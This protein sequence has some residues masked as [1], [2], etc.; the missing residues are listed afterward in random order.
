MIM[1]LSFQGL[2][3]WQKNVFWHVG[4][5]HDVCVQSSMNIRRRVSIINCRRNATVDLNNLLPC[6]SYFWSNFALSL[7][8]DDYRRALWWK[9]GVFIRIWGKEFARIHKCCCDQKWLC[10]LLSPCFL[11][12]VIAMPEDL[13]VCWKHCF[14]LGTC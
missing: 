4:F 5:W 13:I 8:C 2:N 10:S 11:S 7:V 3:S 9:F 12:G 14:I 6:G 1:I